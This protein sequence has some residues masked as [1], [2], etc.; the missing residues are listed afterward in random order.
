MPR[1]F[2]ADEEGPHSSV[3]SI[4][5]TSELEVTRAGYEFGSGFFDI[6]PLTDKAVASL[7]A[8]VVLWRFNAETDVALWVAN[9]RED[10]S[11]NKNGYFLLQF[12]KL[13]NDTVRGALRQLEELRPYERRAENEVDD[14]LKRSTIYLFWTDKNDDK[15]ADDEEE[16]IETV[17]VRLHDIPH[18]VAF[19]G[20]QKSVGCVDGAVIKFTLLYDCS[21]YHRES[22][23]VLLRSWVTA[24]KSVLFWSGFNQDAKLNSVSVLHRWDRQTI[25]KKWNPSFCAR[26]NQQ[27]LITRRVA[28]CDN[29]EEKE[30]HHPL[31]LDHLFLKLAKKHPD[32]VAVEDAQQGFKLTYRKLKM[33]VKDFSKR[34][35]LIEGVQRGDRVAILLPRCIDVYVAML[36][37]MMSGATYVPID[38][39]Y[40]LERIR[41]TLQNSGAR[42]I[43]ARSTQ[44][45]QCT[46]VLTGGTPL[47]CSVVWIDVDPSNDEAVF[48]Y[49]E[50]LHSRD[51]RLRKSRRIESRD[52]LDLAY[53]IYTSGSTGH[54]KGVG[55]SH[56]NAL[57][58]IE[59]EAKIFRVTPSDRVLQGYSTA[60]DASFEEIWMAWRAGA[61][62]VIGSEELMLSGPD[63]GKRLTA[64]R[65]SCFSTVPT[66]LATIPEGSLPTVNLIIVGAEACP[67][68]IVNRWATGDRRF[69]NT[70]GP[71]ETTV[72]ATALQ[73]FPSNNPRVCIGKPLRG[74]SAFI[75]DANGRLLPPGCIGELC[76]GGRAVATGGYIG[77]PVKTAA[78][79]VPQTFYNCRESDENSMTMCQE[80]DSSEE[81]MY[82]TGDYARFRPWDGMIEYHGR[83]DCQIKIRGFRVELSEIESV[84]SEVPCV[85]AAIVDFRDGRLVAWIACS[86]DAD[87]QQQDEK[88]ADVC[89]HVANYARQHLAEYMVPCA[90]Y[91]ID[92]VPTHPSGKVN[93][94]ALKEKKND[95][96]AIDMDAENSEVASEGENGIGKRYQWKKRLGEAES[97][98]LTVFEKH[99]GVGAVRSIS[100]SF[101]DLGGHSLLVSRAVT[102]LREVFCP[103]VST[104]DFYDV[105]GRL[106]QLANRLHGYKQQHESREACDYSEWVHKLHK[107]RNKGVT[108]AQMSVANYIQI[109]G[110]W[111][112]A[113]LGIFHGYGGIIVMTWILLNSRNLIIVVPIYTAFYFALLAYSLIVG[114]L[115]KAILIG[116]YREGVY[117]LWGWYH[118]R[119][120]F[121]TGLQA[122]AS[123]LLF[124]GT[125][126]AP[127]LYKSMGAN[128]E[129]GVYIAGELSPEYDLISI[130]ENSTLNAESQLKCHSIKNR[131]LILRKITIGKNV[132]L[133]QRTVVCGGAIVGDGAYIKPFSMVPENTNIPP[134]E[135]WQGSPAVPCKKDDDALEVELQEGAQS[136]TIDKKGF[137]SSGGKR[138]PRW[139][140]LSQLALIFFSVPVFALA[141]LPALLLL[142]ALWD[143][144]PRTYDTYT[145]LSWWNITVVILVVNSVSVISGFLVFAVLIRLTRFIYQRCSSISSSEDN[146]QPLASISFLCRWYM[147]R[148]LSIGAGNARLLQGTLF[149]QF[150]AR[151]MGA[152]VTGKLVELS[153]SINICTDS[154]TLGRASFI[155]DSVM[156][157]CTVVSRNWFR[158][159]PVTIGDRTFVGNGSHVMD[160]SRL[161]SRSLIALQTAAPAVTATGTT[162]LGSPPLTVDAR[163]MI[164]PNHGDSSTSL[165]YQPS[166]SRI[167]ARVLFEGMG[168]FIFHIYSAVFAAIVWFAIDGAYQQFGGWGSFWAFLLYVPS[169]QLAGGIL[170]L[171]AI[172]IT[173]RIV[174]CGRF[175]E[176]VFP[177]YSFYVWRT[178]LIER[179]E[180][181]IAEPIILNSL[182]GTLLKPWFY[183]A[184]GAKIGKHAYLE[185]AV[186]T[187][188]DMITIGDNVTIESG[189]TLQAHLFQ[190]RLRTVAPIKVGD[191]CS[192]G[193]NSVVLLGTELESGVSISPLSLVLR[194]EKLL[195]DTDWHGSPVVRS[196]VYP[197]SKLDFKS[198]KIVPDETKEEPSEPD[199][200]TSAIPANAHEMV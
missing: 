178:E 68:E 161:G 62:I 4:A 113:G 165:T 41:Y 100:D 186:I 89:K 168:Y 98:V 148:L 179:L 95:F 120:W 169:V 156:L 3:P 67:R 17:I 115:A 77:M 64:L 129:E 170:L 71:T 78:S 152:R 172:V 14:E 28:T 53:I 73:C 26:S 137:L 198:L 140:T 75:V 59:G 125:S 166:R 7:A 194:S 91:V 195:K 48:Y 90:F 124:H 121:V 52:P 96:S 112:L 69:F 24:F 126:V 177:L 150:W 160:G 157:G 171:I 184:M 155:A 79:F 5:V 134:G 6:S 58:L 141:F 31:T 188:P 56:A 40:P 175:K 60:F 117:R 153:S 105:R 70:Y 61:T 82:R 199:T 142:R 196:E 108:N 189:G 27:Q 163:E 44:E 66:L 10:H 107:K 46:V 164:K 74:Y 174:M 119:W 128:I 114:G 109:L 183:R 43:V 136:K 110:L 167:A 35:R 102:D 13:Q 9:P 149:M 39:K 145:G 54:P 158:L 18:F 143:F 16:D 139:L 180:E 193:G 2:V 154:L 133:D 80:E 36:A 147:D 162:H 135:M 104:R 190:D 191:S 173:K 63:L 72:V 132:T 197:Y 85:D 99:L 146:C 49:D 32:S 131:V 57:T 176:G 106:D 83:Q 30:R 21:A 187:E 15:Q 93:K 127:F 159:R 200:P 25:L 1:S 84:L 45:D 122:M 8:S 23:E 50:T 81:L 34:L 86:S 20:Q 101:F 111:M 22:M 123:I 87:L 97:H 181:N 11:T 151:L 76:I 130:G 47:S 55:I 92:S 144:F 33:R 51:R 88:N 12:E 65:I 103:T 37:I 182:N 19:C 118:L 192:I 29:M 42:L 138:L 185:K 94:G 38:P 116:K